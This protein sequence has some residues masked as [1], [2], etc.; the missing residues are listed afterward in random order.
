MRKSNTGPLA[1]LKIL[2]FSTLLPGPYATMLLAD[3]G[4]QVL[5]IES[6]TRADLL[7]SMPPLHGGLS[8]AHLSINRNK[9]SLAIDLK[10]TSAKEI[11]IKLLKDYDILIEQ[12]RPGVMEKLGLDYQALKK[13]NPRLIYCSI[14]G[15]GQT[16]PY[17]DR[18]G[19]DINYL[20]LS[21]LASY[22]G[23][24]LTGPSLSAT[25]IADLAGGSHQAVISIQAAVIARQTT[26]LGQHLDVS[27]CDAT[28]SLN[29]LFG[30][31]AL[32]SGK[33][34]EYEDQFLNGGS[35]YDYYRTLDHRYLSIGAL[36]PKFAKL[37]FEAINQPHWLARIQQTS[38]KQ[39]DLK[40]DIAAVIA[41][42]PL[43]H[44][45]KIFARLDACV[46]PVL[47]I[48]EAASHPQ[49]KARQMIIELKLD[50]Q[51]TAR[52]IAPVIK[53]SDNRNNFWPAR[54]PGQDSKQVLIDLGYSPEQIAKF[55]SDKTI[56][57][58][59]E[60]TNIEDN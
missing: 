42:Q 3:M 54:K 49:L 17:K 30:A 28:F 33:D 41:Q 31:A 16:G 48:S 19:H 8:F 43:A 18:A 4:A 25:Q 1:D 57:N 45:R 52:Q 21:G 50:D 32:A 58:Y 14:T 38:G 23:R 2:D 15:Y 39:T 12:F 7:K 9:Q 40:D 29:S 11:I 35:Y 10:N 22:G 37:F 60:K 6:P 56:I 55:I 47:S 24:K 5:R 46:E 27:I 20:A 59:D 34:P 44:W 26:G 53:F 51:S 13:I 36:E